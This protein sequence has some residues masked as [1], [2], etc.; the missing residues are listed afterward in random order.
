MELE[1]EKNRL[2][3]MYSNDIESKKSN[4][5]KMINKLLCEELP[6]IIAD[7]DK[8]EERIDSL[9]DDID[10]LNNEKKKIDDIVE[11]LNN[12]NKLINITKGV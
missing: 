9:G 7:I 3:E 11:Q 10:A 6:G 5:Q 2:N 12:L 8:C 1:K 4:L